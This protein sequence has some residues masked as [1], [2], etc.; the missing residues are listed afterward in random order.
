MLSRNDIEVLREL[1]CRYAQYAALPVH[2]EKRKLW[3]ENN[4]CRSARPMVL[5]TAQPDRIIE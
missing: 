1:A 4:E 3:I 5:I 2:A